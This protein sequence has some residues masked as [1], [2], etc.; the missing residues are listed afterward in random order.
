MFLG[1]STFRQLENIWDRLYISS[2]YNSEEICL[3][4]L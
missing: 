4:L 1:N 2:N 3:V